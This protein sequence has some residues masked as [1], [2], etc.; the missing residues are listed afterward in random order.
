MN[1]EEDSITEAFR[2]A[3]KLLGH[4]HVGECN[5]KPPRAGGLP[6]NEIGKVLREIGYTGNVVMEPFVTQGGQVG[7]DIKV[8]R[9][10]SNG[11]D[12]QMMDKTIQES[13]HFLR[14]AFDEN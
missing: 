5:R 6:W 2:T 8:W 14:S 13:L 7:R 4:I 9:D 3:G 1:I 11:A 10:L 12:L